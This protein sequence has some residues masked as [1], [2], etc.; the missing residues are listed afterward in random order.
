MTSAARPAGAPGIAAFLRAGRRPQTGRLVVCAGDSI[1]RGQSSANWVDILQRRFAAGGYQFINAGIDGD[2]AWNVL[3]R[4]DDVARCQPDAVTL[5]VGTNDAAA[6]AG[7]WQEK[8]YRRQQHLPQAPT[9]GWYTECVEEILTRLQSQTSARIA[10]LDIPMI[11]EDLTSDI[12]RRV[13]SYNQ[14]LRRV[15]AAHA[16]EYLPLHDRLASLLPS[17]HNP[18]P[19][20]GRFG[21]M[22]RASLSH[23]ILR[24]SWDQISASNGLTVLIDHVHLNDRAA[25]LTADLVADF[26]TGS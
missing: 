26:I 13:D 16:A 17:P 22:I 5:Q 20:R 23:T 3:Q 24:R 6:T 14:A 2:P 12:N 11:G 7:T 10:V 19:Y 4:I 25:A 15:T 9:L 18:P 8:M 1:T 21:P